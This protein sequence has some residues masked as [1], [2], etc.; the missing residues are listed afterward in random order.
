MTTPPTPR[1]A[2]PRA[3]PRPRTALQIISLVFVLLLVLLVVIGT[4]DLGDAVIDVLG[5]LLSLVW[6][7]LLVAPAI[8]LGALAVR[9]PVHIGKEA[10]D[11]GRTSA[12]ICMV[13]GVALVMDALR[14]ASTLALV[15]G[16]AS[17]TVGAWVFT[18]SWMLP[19]PAFDQPPRISVY[20][21][22]FSMSVVAALAL[23]AMRVFG[24][25]ASGF[26]GADKRLQTA[27]RSDLRNMVTSQDKYRDSVGR[28]GTLREIRAAGW[29]NSTGV[30]LSM[31][32]DSTAW[33]A[34]ATHA[35]VP[36]ECT[37]WKGKRPAD[38][39][40]EGAEGEPHCR[41]P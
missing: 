11:L 21:F 23:S 6:I 22:L 17:A 14:S 5:N 13:V 28:F 38:P 7:A 37:N 34:I 4:I 15:G 30:Y 32:V 9:R 40:F 18:R 31:G 33:R 20:R 24:I 35:V 27:M 36:E 3:D 12:V 2:P 39:R 8:A 26:I 41:K 25:T 1:Q 29:K 16:L 10:R 19:R